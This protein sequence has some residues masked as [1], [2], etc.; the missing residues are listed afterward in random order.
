MNERA[1]DL[2]AI[3]F[4]HLRSL[5]V[6]LDEA[7]VGRAA[8]RL[9]ITPPAA[10]NALRRLRDQLG[11][12]LLVRAGSSMVRT[13]L[14]EAL[15][16][17]A[18]DFMRA[19]EALV[20]H[21]HSRFD[22]TSWRGEFSLFTSEYVFVSLGARLEVAL[23]AQVPGLDLTVARVHGDVAMWL[24]G[25]DGLAITPLTSR[26]PEVRQEELFTDRMVAVLRREHPLAGSRLTLA[27][28]CSLEHVLVSLR[29][30]PGS[31][32]DPILEGLGRRRRVVRVV[33][34]H[35][36]AAHI[37]ATTDC[38]TTAPARYVE[39]VGER[40]GLV[41]RSLPFDLDTV[42]FR[43]QWHRRHDASGIHVEMRRI[44]REAAGR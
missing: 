10:S 11:D 30:R 41:G 35:A 42:T 15:R 1:P 17:P 7:N 2:A 8:V 24:R 27:R 4:N 25:Q 28:F 13:S 43:T 22:P 3:D 12:P 23:R 39:S 37:V 14:G 36:L 34:S 33:P 29:G 38:V 9:G 18:A 40:H 26:S 6:L 44:L 19:A 31:M 32:V 21:G 20:N 16:G 5:H